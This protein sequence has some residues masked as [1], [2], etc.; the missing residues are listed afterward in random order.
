MN[1]FVYEEGDTELMDSQCELCIFR[2]PATPEKCAKY[3]QKPSEVLQNERRCP[4]FSWKEPL[5]FE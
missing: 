3:S 4:F 1:R 5:P 2:D